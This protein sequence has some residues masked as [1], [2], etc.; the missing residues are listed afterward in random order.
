M[1]IKSI[2]VS[3]L[4]MVALA[5]CS[6][7]DKG[8]VPSIGDYDAAYM[9]IRVI[10]PTGTPTRGSNE[11]GAEDYEKAISSMYAITFDEAGKLVHHAKELPAQLL[12]GSTGSPDAIRVSANVKEILLIANP[13]TEVLKVL[14]NA[15]AGQT[16]TNLNTAI[17]LA[18]TKNTATKPEVLVNEIRKAEGDKNAT[19]TY[20]NFTMINSNGLETIATIYKVGDTYKTEEAA[21]E[22]A[23]NDSNRQTIKIER[24]TAKIV[25]KEGTTVAKPD[26][27]SFALFTDYWTL[28]VLNSTFFPYAEKTQLTDIPHL[29][30]GG[31]YANAFYTKDPNY[32][33]YTGL[34]Y[35]NLVG[36][37]MAP[38]VTWMANAKADYCIENTME[39]PSQLFQNAT[40][41]ILKATYYPVSTWSGDWYRYAG[42]NYET[43]A[44][45]Q[46]AYDKIKDATPAEVNN[47]AFKVACENFFTVVKA[48]GIGITANDF[49]GLTQAMLDASTI[50]NGG[51]WVKDENGCIRWYQ[52]GL[53]YYY[54][55]IR[56][57]NT[58]DAPMNF[59]KYG[60]V[61]NNQ[62][63]LTLTKVSGHGTPWYP[64]VNPDPNPT[65]PNYPDPKPD[66]DPEPKPTDPIDEAT[67]YISFDVEVGPWVYW[68]TGME[69]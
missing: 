19:V 63:S 2:L 43:L 56:H 1:K 47:Y 31:F 28:D 24:L 54:Y 67:G 59:A 14:N 51:E 57:D 30:S 4:A 12:T 6:N 49:A 3:M 25:V 29:P 35:N 50:V 27:S 60:V 32:T 46:A 64:S 7:E 9:S 17:A 55:E 69:I 44:D 22:A 10:T 65:D 58:N 26:G 5:S 42:T 15:F 62:Y 40:R 37:T 13:G 38:N 68:E 18:Y 39:A 21:K 41:I 8:D 45:L 66:P 53:N 48:K 52:K 23:N 61:R 36:A 33:G 11:Q 16:F 34:A 20:S